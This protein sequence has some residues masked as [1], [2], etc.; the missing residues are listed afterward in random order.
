MKYIIIKCAR[1]KLN[2]DEVSFYLCQQV[3]RYQI[4]I[5]L[6]LSSQTKDE[7]TSAA[8]LRLKGHGCNIS[9]I[10]ST[11]DDLL[12]K[13]IYPVGFWKVACIYVYM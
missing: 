2:S 13:L 11:S 12:G 5:S 3:Y 10:L 9:N 8:L 4:L 7:V 6:M 1:C